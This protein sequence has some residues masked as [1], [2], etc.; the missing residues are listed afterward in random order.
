VNALNQLGDAIKYGQAWMK[1]RRVQN[2]VASSL[3]SSAFGVSNGITDHDTSDK[4][5]IS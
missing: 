3:A 2:C 1:R 4:K 5:A